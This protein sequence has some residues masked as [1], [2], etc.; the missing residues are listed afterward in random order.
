[1]VINHKD[2]ITEAINNAEYT[3][4]FSPETHFLIK[5]TLPHLKDT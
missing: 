4:Y 1:M 2:I 3:F 5:D